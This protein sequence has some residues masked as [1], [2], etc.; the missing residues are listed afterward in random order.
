MS[1]W[2]LAIR[3]VWR[4]TRRT[5]VTIMAVALS[6]AGLMLFGGYVSWAHIAGEVHTVML[7]GHL[8]LFKKGFAEKGSGN[9]AAYALSNYEELRTLLVSDPVL[10]PMVELV[11]G[12]LVVQGMVSHAAT[13]TSATFAGIGARAG[14]IERIIR[15]NPYGLTE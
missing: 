7:S 10:S 2:S 15:W 9:P 12:Q 5:I 8:Q 11:T 6:C 14:D 13:Q 1:T 3:N 4:N